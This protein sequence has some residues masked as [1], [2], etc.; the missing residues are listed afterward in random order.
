MA[1]FFLASYALKQHLIISGECAEKLADTAARIASGRDCVKVYASD[2]CNVTDLIREITA[3]PHDCIC[4]LNGLEQNHNVVKA[5]MNHFNDSLF[6]LTVPY[7]ESLVMEPA[8][9]YTTFFP[10][11]SEE[12]CVGAFATDDSDRLS[13]K[14][15][16]RSKQHTNPDVKRLRGIRVQQASW[17]ASGFFSPMLMERCAHMYY[18]MKSMLASPFSDGEKETK[19]AML[20]QVYVPLMRCLRRKD[21]LTA[22]VAEFDILDEVRKKRLL[23]FAGVE[24]E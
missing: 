24:K 19:A 14:L 9:L 18:E 10:V 4:L 12:F 2:H 6:I 1:A 11:C 5:M 23:A 3:V 22:K 8:S 17:F 7:H 20:S 16:L 21:I 13:C 15:D